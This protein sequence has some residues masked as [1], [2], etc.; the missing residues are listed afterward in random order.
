MVIVAINS[1]LFLGFMRKD[2]QCERL[3]VSEV[4]AVMMLSERPVSCL[5]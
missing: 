1:F 2:T 5:M 3:T 4:M